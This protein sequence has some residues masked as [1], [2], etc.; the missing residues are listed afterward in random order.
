MGLLDGLFRLNIEWADDMQ[1]RMVYKYPFKKSGKEVND[2]S[3]LTVRE[4]QVAIFVHK[5]K[6]ADVFEPGL[7]QMSTEILPILTKLASWKYKFETPITLDVY[8]VNTKQF[9]GIKWGTQ[10]PFMMRDPEFGVI[11]VRGFGSFAFRVDDA[12]TFMRE[13]FGTASSFETADI[14]NYLK[15]MV[16]SGLTDAVG[17]S[18]ISAID[19]AGNTMEFQTIVKAKIQ[20]MFKNIG[21]ELTQLIIENMSVPSEV[22]KALDERSKYGILGDATDVMLKVSAAEA[23]KEAAKNPGAGGAMMGAGIGMGAGVGMGAMMGEAFKGTTATGATATAAAAAAGASM[24]ATTS[25]SGGMITCPECSA[26]V[27]A[28]SKFCSNCGKKLPTKKFCTNCG[29][30]VALG[31]KFCSN[32]GKKID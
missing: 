17:E 30:E 25:E 14:Q 11:R 5:G 4:S 13:L 32:C 24:A 22:E 1:N 16:V 3:S 2:N 15:S 18:K 23:M 8:F 29:T 6:I 12:P 31:A 10:N 7:Y 21:L 27:S 20:A 26:S 9:T 28:G 19:L